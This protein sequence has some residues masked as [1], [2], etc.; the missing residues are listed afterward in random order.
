[1][2]PKR[3]ILSLISQGSRRSARN[4]PDFTTEEG[5]ERR[6]T[7][8]RGQG[9]GA[10]YKTYIKATEFA[11]FG[12]RRMVWSPRLGRIV[13]LFSELEWHIFIYAEFNHRYISIRENFPLDRERTRAIARMLGVRHPRPYCTDVV[14]TTDLLIT[15]DTP[16]GPRLLAWTVKYQ[17]DLR[18]PR[19]RE[20]LLIEQKYFEAEGIP[21]VVM[22]EDSVP[23]EVIE[24]LKY[25]RATQRL[26]AFVDY[27]AE[28]L[29]AIDAHMRP[30]LPSTPFGIVCD[31]C[32]EQ[33]GLEPGTAV[34]VARHFIATHRWPIDLTVAVT[35]EN[36][37]QLTPTS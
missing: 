37:L 24:N 7:E 22:T 13:H 15:E 36:L 2:K 21:Y 9:D 3:K 27:S 20:K 28:L 12:Y 32:D 30:L 16:D 19:V 23:S 25:V 10:D 17:K 29:N 4:R 11:S 8:G 33:L 5:I 18:D 6:L 31:A 26:D 14:M 1:M 35:I 34:L